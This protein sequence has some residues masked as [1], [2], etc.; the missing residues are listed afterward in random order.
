[1]KKKEVQQPTLLIGRKLM[2]KIC[3]EIKKNYKNEKIKK[4]K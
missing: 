3:K 4:R 2:K 1:M